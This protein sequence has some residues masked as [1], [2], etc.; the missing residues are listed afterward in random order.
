[1]NH[2]LNGLDDCLIQLNCNTEYL[3]IKYELIGIIFSNF[4]SGINE[5]YFTYCKSP[6]NK[7]WYCYNDSNIQNIKDPTKENKGIPYI[8]F[9]QKI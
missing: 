8:L 2:I 1:M 9:Y 5:Q 4:D 3:G 7:K 6:V